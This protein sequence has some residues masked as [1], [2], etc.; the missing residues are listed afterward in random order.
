VAQKLGFV[1]EGT[2]RCDE[3][4]TSGELRNTVIYSKIAGRAG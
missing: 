2:L 1:E 4:D 3:R